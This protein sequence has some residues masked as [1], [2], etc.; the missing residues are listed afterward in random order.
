MGAYSFLLSAVLLIACQ[1]E[2]PQLSESKGQPTELLVVAPARM[3]QGENLDTLNTVV[4]CDA[5][6]LGS[7]ERIFRTM[8]IGE[9]GYEKIY[10]LMHS[11]LHLKIDPSVKETS[12]GVAHDIYARPQLQLMVK[13]ATE[14]QMRQFLSE[15]R[16]RIQHIIMDFQLD[17]HAGQLRRKYSKRVCD[18]LK[19]LGYAVNMP[20]DMVATKVGK[21]FLWGS[22]N[23]G[24]DKDIHFVFYTY[25]WQGEEVADTT[26][27]VQKNDSVLQANIPGSR[28]DQWMT[29]SRGQDGNPVLWPTL[30]M[31]N[32]HRHYEV[33]G[34]WE[35]HHGFMG[36]PFV[37]YVQVDTAARQVVVSEGFVFSPNSAKRDL[38]RSVES[39]LRTLHKIH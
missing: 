22:S 39:G 4:D 9:K 30:R 8:T 20:T 7:S 3:L 5:P 1:E 23:R 33:R 29:I 18:D 36:G 19:R 10:K 32:G 38:L 11:Q 13:A 28:P 17:R 14:E 25:P 34:L 2:K 24:G 26:L 31:R 21:K 6:G 12:L 15:N 35:M 37:A 27:F 16:E